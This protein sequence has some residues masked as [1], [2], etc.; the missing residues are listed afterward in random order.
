MSAGQNCWTVNYAE[1]AYSE[2]ASLK[3]DEVNRGIVALRSG[4]NGAYQRF[5]RYP[6]VRSS[7]RQG[8]ARRNGPLEISNA[9]SI[10]PLARRIALVSDRACARGRHPARPA[11]V[12]IQTSGIA[13]TGAVP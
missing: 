5:R 3:R 10:R 2:H 9:H 4:P 7:Q 13:D 6:R 1:V 12:G 8:P 11:D